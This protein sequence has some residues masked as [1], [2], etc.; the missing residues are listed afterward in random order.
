M[1][2]SRLKIYISLVILITTMA[3]AFVQNMIFPPSPMPASTASPI[4]ENTTAAPATEAPVPSSEPI[5]NPEPIVC[6]NDECLNACLDRL[7]TVLETS[8]LDS[9]GNTIYEE[10]SAE[11]NLVIYKV[12]GD[13]IVDPAIL[14]VPSE[15]RKYQEDAAS[16]LRIWKFY[17]A[18]IPPELRKFVS[19]FVIY[20]DGPEGD[21]VAWVNPSPADADYWQVGF[22]LLDADY[23]PFLADSLIHETAHV[24]TL[25]TSQIP[26]DQ[27]Q[28]YL[29]DPKQN[30][31]PG[32]EQYAVDGSCTLPDSYINLFYQKFWKDSYAEWWEMEQE[33]EDAGTSDEYFESM[34]Q[35]YDEH[36]DWFI[37][38]YAATSVEEDMAESFSFFALN[39]KPS[40]DSIYEQKVAFYYDFPELVEYRRQMIEG[41]C[42]YIR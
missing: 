8:P 24:L 3:C 26:S 20:T 31:V 6:S 27:D 25:N 7:S 28:Y 33:A 23:P 11:F 4:V 13:E 39:P 12:E 34:E 19:E 16:H 5:N 41:L 21:S 22:D 30:R 14:Y 32:C 10:Q 29:Y 40:G 9:I 42:S 18:I 38:S 35:F 37:D 15:Y 36:S 2:G 17:A 1:M